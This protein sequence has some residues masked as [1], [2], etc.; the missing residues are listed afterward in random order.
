MT[1][2]CGGAMCGEQSFTCASEAAKPRQRRANENRTRT[3]EIIKCNYIQ[4]ITTRRLRQRR[5]ADVQNLSFPR[6]RPSCSSLRRRSR[7]YQSKIARSPYARARRR[8]RVKW[9][10]RALAPYRA[11]RWLFYS[12]CVRRKVS[13]RRRASVSQLWRVVRSHAAPN[14]ARRATRIAAHT[15]TLAHTYIARAPRVLKCSPT[16]RRVSPRSPL[17]ARARHLDR[18]RSRRHPSRRWRALPK[19]S[20]TSRSRASTNRARR[21]FRASASPCD[22]RAIPIDI[23]NI[24]STSTTPHRATRRSRAMAH[25]AANDGENRCAR[26]GDIARGDARWRDDAGWMSCF[27][28]EQKRV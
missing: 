10:L 2:A 9:N 7:A 12:L 24:S 3:H 17:D 16:P 18:P 11:S 14:R 26:I 28:G 22:A 23:Q 27:R 8:A 19:Q 5:C 15:I 13:Q 1:T 21:A 4:I 20:L 25:D 6:A